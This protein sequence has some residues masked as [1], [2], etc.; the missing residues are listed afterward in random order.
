MPNP[1]GAP[2]RQQEDETAQGKTNAITVAK[3]Y[4]ANKQ[5]EHAILEVLGMLSVLELSY[6]SVSKLHI[7]VN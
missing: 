2:G 5:F 1:N 4:V 3:W 6:F 7:V